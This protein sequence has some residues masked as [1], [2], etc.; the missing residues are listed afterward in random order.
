MDSLRLL[1]RRYL[2]AEQNRRKRAAAIVRPADSGTLSTLVT[3]WKTNRVLW[4]ETGRTRQ[5]LHDIGERR[6]SPAASARRRSSSLRAELVAGWRHAPVREGP[7]E[8]NKNAGVPGY[9]NQS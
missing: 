3:G 4:G 1:P 6:T 9:A 5:D 8:W 2:M 7:A